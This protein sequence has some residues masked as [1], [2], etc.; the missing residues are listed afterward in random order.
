MG[1]SFTNPDGDRGGSGFRD[2]FGDEDADGGGAEASVGLVGHEGLVLGELLL[3][4]ERA[5][6]LVLDV[7]D[8]KHG[9]ADFFGIGEAVLGGVGD[10]SGG[11]GGRGGDGIFCGEEFGEVPAAHAAV[12]AG[13]AHL[14]GFDEAGAVHDLPEPDEHF[15]PGLG[16]ETEGGAVSL[17]E[18]GDAREAGFQVLDAGLDVGVAD[19]FA[20]ARFDVFDAVTG[21]DV[22]G[23]DVVAAGAESGEGLVF[24]VGEGEHGW[25]RRKIERGKW[26]AE[27]LVFGG[28]WLGS[29]V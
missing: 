23:G 21:V 20:G 6:A 5:G 15:M 28:E 22:G 1:G 14:G 17:V 13:G 7:F 12:E 11:R 4:D 8:A 18:F 26:K 19:Q 27:G 24:G 29:G 2:G 10:G 3:G 16:H 25:G 9:E